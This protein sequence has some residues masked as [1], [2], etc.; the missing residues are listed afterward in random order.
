MDQN[1][2]VDVATLLNTVAG[3]LAQS[4]QGL[5]SLDQGP[6]GGTH[7]QRMAEAFRL[8]A[9]AAER[10]R[11]DDAG[12]QLEIAAE[13][14]RKGGQGRAAR[15]YADGLAESAQEFRGQSGISMDQLLPFL[16]SFLGGVQR[17]NP[18][19]PGQGTMIDALAPAIGALSGAQ[20]RGANSQSSI[21]DAL[22]AALG[23]AQQT[24]RG[25]GR[26]DPGAASAVNVIGGIVAALA[27]SII[28]ALMSGRQG[29]QQQDDYSRLPGAGRAP[30]QSQDPFGGLG[31][32]LGGLLGGQGQGGLGTGSGN[33]LG[34]LL[35]DLT[36]GSDR[37]RYT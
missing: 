3:Q 11:T 32:L 36:D 21:L 8:A 2:Q 9:N 30:A 23:G 16:Q 6:N 14:M 28:G 15:F 13:A 24:E 37:R 35:G 19:Q 33:D 10:S 4:Q 34:S 29:A 22:G 31:G 17:N 27:P 1:R 7:G 12:R 5:D 20:Q 18:A 25:Q 26:V